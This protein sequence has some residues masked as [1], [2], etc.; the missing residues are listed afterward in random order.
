[1][2]QSIVILDHLS[3]TGNT[4]D[5]S[6]ASD[7]IESDAPMAA[8][9]PEIFFQKNKVT[10]IIAV[11]RPSVKGQVYVAAGLRNK[12]HF[13][14]PT[15]FLPD[16]IGVIK[17][18]N[19]AKCEFTFVPR[20]VKKYRK[21]RSIIVLNDIDLSKDISN[22]E[23][24]DINAVLI[25]AG[26]STSSK[27]SKFST[28]IGL[29]TMYSHGH[30][31]ARYCMLSHSK[32]HVTIVKEHPHVLTDA[33]LKLYKYVN[34]E[35][36]GLFE[37]NVTHP[38]L[39]KDAIET[40][41]E[42]RHRN[43]LRN[44]LQ[45]FLRRNS[46]CEIPD[47][48]MFESCSVQPTSALGF[49]QDTMNC[50]VLD[51]TIACFIPFLDRENDERKCIS[52]L[53]Y[54]RK[55]VMEHAKKMSLIDTFLRSP[56]VSSSSLTQFCVR[57]M[58][59]IGGVFDYQ[60]SLFE[61]PMSLNAIYKD[62]EKKRGHS[63]P[64]IR[65]FTGL[66]CFKHGAAFDKMGYYSVFL[67]VFLSLHFTGVAMNI[68]DSISLCIFFG[69]VCNGTTALAA[70]WK[71]FKEKQT[72][73]VGFY[74]RKRSPT[75]LF[76]I[77]I[78]LDRY[79]QLKTDRDAKVLHGNCLLPR[80]QYAG[81]GNDIVENYK[82]IHV[83]LKD[84][85]NQSDFVAMPT[86]N[87][88]KQHAYLYGKL[89]NY[90]GIGPLSFNQFWHS[91]CLCG[92]LPH[93]F[94]ETSAIAPGSGP[95]Q[96]IQIFQPKLKRNV[97][98]NK[99]LTEVRKEFANLGFNRITEFFIENMMC[100]L[101]RIAS[102]RKLFTKNMSAEDKKDI[103]MT[104][105]FQSYIMEST[106]TRFPD[107]YFSSPFTNEMQ[108]LFRMVEKTLYMRPSFLNNGVG[109]SSQLQCEITYDV[110]GKCKV[111]LTGEYLRRSDVSCADLFIS[112]EQN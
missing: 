90:K 60:A 110:D 42:G 52:F 39:V 108:H 23:C 13:S 112:R 74:E 29:Q 111:S 16:L 101:V 55:S 4:D 17:R 62:I 35:I 6:N 86:S 27:R 44:D 37:T 102:F 57:S 56:T 43:A 38:F 85:L 69:F 63:C 59:H 58:M 12:Y 18:I 11:E 66:S 61:S 28:S 99:K 73:A 96:L 79:R 103:L 97:D 25:A 82:G 68:D 24:N 80:Y 5:S 47:N 34:R 9:G 3:L 10:R 50:P 83:A 41:T 31:L 91:L 45:S 19:N 95:A 32:P 65:E 49:H 93:H 36:D 26:S 106:S 70:V 109:G 22:D 94:I 54:S 2:H 81:Y 87:V 67:N 14:C 51:D 48:I 104:S 105:K 46:K 88:Q 30:H 1:M 107:L 100:E 7:S 89:K 33:I 77:L 53:Y 72:W 71:A 92:I 84:F 15:N 78:K 75:K 20:I 8:K 21:E 76:K 40:C 98:M 64:E